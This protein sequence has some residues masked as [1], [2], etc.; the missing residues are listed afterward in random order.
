MNVLGRLVFLLAAAAALA[1]AVSEAQTIIKPPPKGGLIPSGP[2]SMAPRG[3]SGEVISGPGGS[4]VRGPNSGFAPPTG[5]GGV[6]AGQAGDGAPVRH[7]TY[8]APTGHAFYY[9]GRAYYG[10]YAP[11][12]AYPQGWAYRRW[13]VGAVLPAVF[14]TR[15]Y[16]YADYAT[17]GLPRPA[18]G[19]RW[20]RY[21]PDL[22]LVDAHSG[23]VV[24]AAH[25]VFVER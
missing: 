25:G 1:P 3:P 20:V 10:V 13:A 17:L 8:G 11:T 7:R 5:N 24:H 19:Q 14:L 12:F 16:A 9:G 15:P 6:A 2:Y 4:A 18:P 23:A 22:L 21:G